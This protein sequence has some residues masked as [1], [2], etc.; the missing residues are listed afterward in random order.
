MP[1]K[2]LMGECF[3]FVV[4]N[5]TKRAKAKYKHNTDR[6][7]DNNYYPPASVSVPWAC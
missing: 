6:Q 3:R 7:S 1:M 2:W 4:R 5:D